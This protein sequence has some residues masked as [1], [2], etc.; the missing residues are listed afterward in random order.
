ADRDVQ[1][2]DADP[3][4]EEPRDRDAEEA[5]QRNGRNEEEPPADWCRLLHRLGDDLGDG[6]EI[7]RSQDE[8]GTARDRVVE[9][10]C[11]RLGQACSPLKGLKSGRFYHRALRES[12]TGAVV[13][14]HAMVVR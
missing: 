7:R 3:F 13:T 2:P 12:S 9:Q 8:R 11:F 4:P 10:F 1:T 5:E 6:M 14:R